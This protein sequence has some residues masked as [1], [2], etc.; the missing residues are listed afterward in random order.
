[1]GGL[2]GMGIDTMGGPGMMGG[3]MGMAAGGCFNEP[4]FR[5]ALS[6]GGPGQP[7]AQLM[8]VL[9]ERLVRQSLVPHGHLTE[10]ADK[11]QI[12]VD[13]GAEVSAGM[14][15]VTLSG[16]VAANSMAAYLL[17]ERSMQYGGCGGKPAV[18][19]RDR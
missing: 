15:Q 7:T 11:C 3:L 13:L 8:L 12:H 18:E 10:I 19:Q 5:A 17:Q 16:S 4:V 6:S 1:M 2:G 9:P 14:L